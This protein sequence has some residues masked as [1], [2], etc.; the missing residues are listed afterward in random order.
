MEAK[1]ME[2]MVNCRFELLQMEHGKY[3]PKFNSIDLVDVIK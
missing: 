3:Q 2:E 1:K